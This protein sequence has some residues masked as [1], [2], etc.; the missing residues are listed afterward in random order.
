M[1]A[2]QKKKIEEEFYLTRGALDTPEG[3]AEAQVDVRK[4]L[5]AIMEKHRRRTRGHPRAVY[6]LVPRRAP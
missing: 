3:Q 4:E 2:E 1:D 5:R 6:L